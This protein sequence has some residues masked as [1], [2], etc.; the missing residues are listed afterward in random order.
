MSITDYA[1]IINKI[2]LY[3]IFYYK[4][5]KIVF[6]LVF[7]SNKLIDYEKNNDILG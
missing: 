7:L 1:K 5:C 4:L 3:N 6:Y 2:Y